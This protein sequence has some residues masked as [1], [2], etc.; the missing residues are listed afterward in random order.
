MGWP[1]PIPKIV[2]FHLV[3]QA[4]TLHRMERN[5]PP[6]QLSRVYLR[7]GFLYRSLGREPE[8][9]AAF[10]RA[11]SA[12]PGNRAAREALR[13]KSTESEAVEPADQN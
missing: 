11:L 4:S 8:A 1:G 13:Q 7:L 3:K 12:D 2:G 10:Q 6:A 5:L 9:R